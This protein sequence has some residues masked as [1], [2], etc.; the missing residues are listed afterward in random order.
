MYDRWRVAALTQRTF[1]ASTG[2]PFNFSSKL[3]GANYG[4][5]V[6][7]EVSNHRNPSV[8]A[9]IRLVVLSSRSAGQVNCTSHQ[10]G[11]RWL[12]SRALLLFRFGD[13]LSLTYVLY[14]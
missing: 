14:Q 1:N 2:T 13:R 10:R 11:Q 7:S 8:V 5:L 6:L 3:R 12:N 9:Y 4:I